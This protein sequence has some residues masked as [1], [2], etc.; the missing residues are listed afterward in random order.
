[1]EDTNL[2]AVAVDSCRRYTIKGCS[3][4]FTVQ[5]LNHGLQTIKRDSSLGGSLVQ[6]FLLEWSW[7]GEAKGDL[8]SGQLVVAV[9]NGSQ[10]VEH[11]LLVEWV[12]EDLLLL[13]AVSGDSDSSSV[14]ERGEAL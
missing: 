6:D 12:K 11:D 3:S 2:F 1:M 14:D 13:S 8:V 10:S 5:A 7:L 9:G 4:K